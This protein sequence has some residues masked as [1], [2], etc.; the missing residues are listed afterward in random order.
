MF[1]DPIASFYELYPYPARSGASD[2]GPESFAWIMP[3]S[4]PAIVH[5]VFQGALPKDRSLR[6]LVAGGGTGDAVLS[7]GGWMERLRISGTI[8]YL[9]LSAT[10]CAI[11]RQRADAAGIANV[12][13]RVGPLEALVDGPA[14]VY[15]YVDFC[16][17]LNHVADPGVAVAALTHAI[18]PGGGIGVMAYGKL[19]RTGVYEVQTAL[20]MLGVRSGGPEAITRTRSLV[21]GLPKTN[22]LKLNPNFGPLENSNDIEVADILLNPRDRAFSTDE[23]DDLM[24]AAGLQIRSFAPAFMY[25][26]TLILPDPTLR[27]AAA[28]LD[29]RSKWRLAELLRGSIRKHVF[30]ATKAGR[31]EASDAYDEPIA[32]LLGEPETLLVPTRIDLAALAASLAEVP[33]GRCSLSVLVDTANVAVGVR[34]S[35]LD[36]SI[37][38]AFAGPTRVGEIIERVAERPDLVH[39]ALRVLQP[40]LTKVGALHVVG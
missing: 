15:D 9:D 25:D 22:W 17:V 12:A 2:G 38:G 23:L 35:K 3:G 13:F 4:L 7:L 24:S 34:L 6:F 11:A 14:E 28:A 1:E 36:L 10:S 18:A 33:D 27:R 21:D 32:R 29:R 19:G 20:A 5:H 39:D 37:L 8:D 30:Y 16:G 40:K 31:A 26:P